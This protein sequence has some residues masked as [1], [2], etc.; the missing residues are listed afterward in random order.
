MH[1]AT[2]RKGEVSVA[3]TV[4]SQ[5]RSGRRHGPVADKV[6]F[7]TIA[8]PLIHHLSTSDRAIEAWCGRGSCR[9]RRA[10][11]ETHAF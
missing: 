9:N 2:L 7:S 1:R 10:A 8:Y 11:Y 6:W 3:D 5:T 4:R